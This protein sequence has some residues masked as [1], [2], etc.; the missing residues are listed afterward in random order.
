MPALAS[1]R[2]SGST[3]KAQVSQHVF[4]ISDGTAQRMAASTRAGTSRT[5]D[6]CRSAYDEELDGGEGF[7]VLRFYEL[8]Q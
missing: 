1:L 7:Y 8:R 3:V 4:G 6:T 2:A 5:G